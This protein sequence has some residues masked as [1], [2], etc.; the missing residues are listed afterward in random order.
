MRLKER[1]GLSDLDHLPEKDELVYYAY[2]SKDSAFTNEIVDLFG[3][4]CRCWHGCG[5]LGTPGKPIVRFFLLHNM[6]TPNINVSMIRGKD[7]L[8]FNDDPF[9]L[10]GDIKGQPT[11]SKEGRNDR[12]RPHCFRSHGCVFERRTHR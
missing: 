8:P 2:I 6:M 4:S 12:K 7:L 3:I 5:Y 11:L 9:P 1:V 10:H